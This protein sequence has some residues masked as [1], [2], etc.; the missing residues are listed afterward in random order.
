[1][2]TLLFAS[3]M[4]AFTL[5]LSG[6]IKLNSAEEAG[7]SYPTV[8]SPW[9]DNQKCLNQPTHP[10][11]A[12]E[13]LHVKSMTVVIAGGEKAI[14]DSKWAKYKPSFP[15]QKNTDR[16]LLFSTSCFARSPQAP[17]DCQGDACR[18][19]ITMDHYSW[20]ALSK[21]DAVDCIP[22]NSSCN[23]GKVQPGEIAVVVS[24]KCHEMTFNGDQIF[25]YGPNG[26]KAIMHATENGKP[27][28]Q[29]QL[30][31]GWFLSKETLT[32]PLVLHPFGGPGFC[33][34]NIIRDQ[35]AQ[36]YHQIKYAKAMYP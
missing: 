18:K 26:E 17:A 7:V 8:E 32:T 27:T 15:N 19:T 24:E 2:N 23:P 6:C 11:F 28:T 30:P 20:T 31:E 5:G 25:L 29:V 14:P 12:K 4:L 13:V 16:H 9:Q 34:Y 3:S 36:S 1:M 10:G 22:R 35:L 21:I 33:Y